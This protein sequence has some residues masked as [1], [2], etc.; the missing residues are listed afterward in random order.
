MCKRT[1]DALYYLK[2]NHKEKWWIIKDDWW[3]TD[4]YL[5]KPM[6]LN[7]GTDHKSSEDVFKDFNENWMESWIAYWDNVGC[8]REINNGRRENK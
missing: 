2:R 3:G 6:Y 5:R 7:W 1:D 8:I 4:E